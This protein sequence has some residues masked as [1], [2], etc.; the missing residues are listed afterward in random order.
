MKELGYCWLG[1]VSILVGLGGVLTSW[2]MV[3]GSL[4]HF[5][6]NVT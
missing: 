4:W 6:D 5:Y 1:R 2:D 3:E